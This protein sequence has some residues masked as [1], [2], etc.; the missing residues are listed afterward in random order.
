MLTKVDA[1]GALQAAAR[2]L[3]AELGSPRM[4]GGQ[5]HVGAE[6]L[7]RLAQERLPHAV[8]EERD[9]R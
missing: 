2:D 4:V 9:A 5:H 6:Q 1:L 7:V 8:G 3:V